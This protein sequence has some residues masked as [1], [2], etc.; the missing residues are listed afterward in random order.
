MM[1]PALGL[2]TEN[3]TSQS[4]SQEAFVDTL[5]RMTF[6]EKPTY[7]RRAKQRRMEGVVWMRALID[8]AGTVEDAILHQSSGHKLLDREALKSALKCRYSPAI[9]DD[10]PTA[11]WVVYKLE[12]SLDREGSEDLIQ[13]PDI[14]G[15]ASVADE[16]SQ[17][18]DR[19]QPVDIVAELVFYAPQVDS[20]LSGSAEDSLEVWIKA[21]IQVDGNVSYALILTGSGDPEF[22][23]TALKA[24]FKNRYRAAIHKGKPVPS[25]VTYLVSSPQD[26]TPVS[27]RAPRLR[28]PMPLITADNEFPKMSLLEADP[29]LGSESPAKEDDPAPDSTQVRTFGILIMHETRPIRG[30]L[31]QATILIDAGCADGLTP[32][33]K[34][35]V[36]EHTDSKP[37]LL[38][39]VEMDDV[40]AFVSA[41]TLT[42]RAGKIVSKYHTVTFEFRSPTPE[43]RL[44]MGI[45][46]YDAG[47]YENALA[48]FESVA[49]LAESNG[50]IDHHLQDCRRR[51]LPAAPAPDTR[52]F[53]AW[54]QRL[55]AYLEMVRSAIRLANKP[56]AQRF[57]DQILAVDSTTDVVLE[58]VEALTVLDSCNFSLEDW[59]K[60]IADSTALDRIPTFTYYEV[61]E[62]PIDRDEFERLASGV[63]GAFSRTVWV[64]ALVSSMGRV[65]KAEL[66][67]S[68]GLSRL[69][70]AAVRSAYADRFQCGLF[71]GKPVTTWVKWPVAYSPFNP[72][73]GGKAALLAPSPENEYPGIHEFVAVDIIAEM[74]HYEVPKYPQM[75]EQAG[76][77]GLVWI[78]ALVGPDGNVKGA[79]IFKSSGTPALDQAALDVAPKCK[80]KPAMQHG[81]PIAMW[82]TYKVD[83]ILSNW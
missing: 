56:V 60:N 58:L 49:W 64:R 34:G 27:G 51:Y 33:M 17:L 12:F 7:P 74:I 55:P 73:L 54:K 2:A 20:T 48:C 4:G 14:V 79:V 41:A 59:Q 78:K 22:D 80:Y 6:Y 16:S 28:Q 8:T 18:P 21:L 35:Q 69:D 70:Q 24:A 71:C 5:P 30:Q 68:S 52:E 50:L 3:D 38:A 61:P 47:F 75:A 37:V 77:Q 53:V 31:T 15:L 44:Q 19:L 11:V 45:D 66:H 32:G 82:V 29:S 1:V 46:Y 65:L 72:V 26:V 25:W 10:N 57:L 40:Q 39:T 63:A 83:F 62:S 42:P 23:Q 13:M 9:K 43:E 76:L 36:W 67:E 81:Q